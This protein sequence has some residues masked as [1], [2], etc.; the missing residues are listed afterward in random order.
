MR[1]YIEVDLPRGSTYGELGDLLELKIGMRSFGNANYRVTQGDG[2]I[3]GRYEGFT[4]TVRW[5]VTGES[6]DAPFRIRNND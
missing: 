6:P 4:D 1:V 2:N 3:V 5:H